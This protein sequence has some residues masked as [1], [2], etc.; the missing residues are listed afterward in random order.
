MKTH[1]PTRLGY[2][3]MLGSLAALG[4]LC[5]DLY[6]PA[7]P[8]LTSDLSTNTSTAQLSLTAGLLGLGGGQLIFGPL[9][10]AFGRMRPLL[11]S[12]ALLLATSIW[13][14]LATD[15]HQLLAAR[16][17]QGIAGAGGAVL[18]RA[19]VRD[20][21]SGHELT[22]FFA[23]LML[24]NGLAPI[25]APVLG[26]ALMSLTDWRGIFVALAIVAMLLLLLSAFRM[27]ET[28]PQERRISGGL[29]AMLS[30][31]GGLL[32]ERQFMGMCLA[33]GLSGAGMFAYIGAS[34]FVL[35][36]IYGLS[37]QIFS[38][39]FALNGIGLIIAGQLSARFSRDNQEE[40]VLRVGL[41]IA[42][43]AS[44]I[45]LAAGL[46]QASLVWVLAPL[47]LAV[48]MIGVIGPCASALAMQSQGNQA[49]SASALIGL[50]MFGLGALSVPLTGL[51]GTSATSMALVMLVCYVLAALSYVLL[52]AKA[53]AA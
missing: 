39:C 34:P 17:L 40:R 12:L 32:R 42:V 2:A 28:L 33:Q 43:L 52:V 26:G 4:P 6:L 20:L 14:A 45:L 29:G 3:L 48:A 18:S 15:I 23:L 1:S 24:V 38:L 5:T 10:D 13:C 31:L 37:P 25:F 11:F 36:Q 8:Q 50:S 22:R 51:A 46:T 30:S 27:S 44:A 41:T 47:F 53:R 21:Y 49:G 16:L 19:V 7:L 9:S 35:Q